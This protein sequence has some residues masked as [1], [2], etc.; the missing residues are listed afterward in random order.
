MVSG[1]S[2]S[3]A[4]D[5]AFPAAGEWV[6]A[7]LAGRVFFHRTVIVL[8]RPGHYVFGTSYTPTRA[9]VASASRTAPPAGAHDGARLG[10]Q[11]EQQTGGERG[12][13]NPV[14][15]K[16]YPSPARPSRPG[17]NGEGNRR[18]LR[19]SLSFG[20]GQTRGA[21]AAVLARST[22]KTPR[23]ATYRPARTRLCPGAPPAC[24]R[25][26][27][28]SSGRPP[29]VGE[30]GS[31]STITPGR[32]GTTAAP[33]ATRARATVL[34]SAARRK[35][36][37]GSR[38]HEAT[39]E[40]GVLNPTRSAPGESPSTVRFVGVIPG[41]LHLLGSEAPVGSAQPPVKRPASVIGGSTPSGP[42]AA[43]P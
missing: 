32:R 30:V 5:R 3:A 7:P 12:R 10:G 2:R 8:P 18:A 36:P 19:H 31:T 27:H 26:D 16:L 14:R 38:V 33:P 29:I 34:R 20:T 9:R 43:C 28:G 41:A 42:T 25:A 17:I 6:G 1:T 13:S 35:D 22:G 40:S 23:S 39:A 4:S 21:T 11:R 15:F 24:R 37:H